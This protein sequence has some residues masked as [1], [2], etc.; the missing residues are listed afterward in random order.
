MVSRKKYSSEFKAES[1][2]L[3]Q[4]SGKA[5]ITVAQDLGIHDSLLRRWVK[6][7]EGDKLSLKPHLPES[8]LAKEVVKLRREND[9]LRM[10]RDII[11]K[12]L[13]YFAKDPL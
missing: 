12:A 6:E 9:K 1:V 13:G 4:Q 5:I 3:V 11:K 8:D 7:S 2:K 10:E